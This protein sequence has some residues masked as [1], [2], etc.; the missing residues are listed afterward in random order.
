M[1]KSRLTLATYE[2]VAELFD[3]WIEDPWACFRVWIKHAHL[4]GFSPSRG[5]NLIDEAF[6]KMS[7]PRGLKREMRKKRKNN[8]AEGRID[9]PPR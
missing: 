8:Q 7:W 6:E 2:F 9:Y 4:A 1:K 5:G 3:F